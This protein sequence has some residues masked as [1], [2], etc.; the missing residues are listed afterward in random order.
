MP[1]AST[2]ASFSTVPMSLSL[3]MAWAKA[4]RTFTSSKGG[5]STL[6]PMYQMSSRGPVWNSAFRGSLGSR[7]RSMSLR[8]TPV[9]SISSFSYMVTAE[10]PARL[11]STRARSG[12]P[13]W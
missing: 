10:P 5:F 11:Y 9:T 7:T 4:W 3:S 12:A 6:K 1:L 8:P 13:R 2:T